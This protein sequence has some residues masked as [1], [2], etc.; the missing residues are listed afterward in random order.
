MSPAASD[1]STAPEL[2]PNQP[3]VWALDTTAGWFERLADSDVVSM[4]E[5]ARAARRSD[6]RAARQL[7]A[8]RSALRM[9]IGRYL[10]E[11]PESIRIVTAPAGKS[12]L[13]PTVSQQR[14][15]SFSAAHSGNLYCVALGSVSSLGLDIELLRRVP[16]ARA[17]AARWFGATEATTLLSAADEAV[18][19]EFMRLWTAKEALAKRHGAGL[20][21]MTGREEAALDI[22]TSAAEGQLR[23][24]FPS[25]GYVAAI[26]STE[27]IDDVDVIRPEGALW[28]STPFGRNG[29]RSKAGG[30]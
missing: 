1:V 18:D 14:T 10:G 28:V 13:V 22:E 7:L 19:A 17:I 11:P 4:E 8:R 23:S 30:V 24:F 21:L 26:A 20:R 6:P 16:R 3:H 12:V 27:V 25:R 15:L 5:R 29:R 2:M 9:V